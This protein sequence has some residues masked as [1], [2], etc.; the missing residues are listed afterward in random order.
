MAFATEMSATV[1]QSTEAP[2]TVCDQE[3]EGF[4]AKELCQWLRRHACGGENMH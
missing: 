2:T 1:H 4:G 3:P